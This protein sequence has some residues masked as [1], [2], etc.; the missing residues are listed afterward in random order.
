MISD[1]FCKIVQK[2]LPAEIV[3]EDEE[4]LV[5]KDIH[6][7]A[8][9]HLLVVPKKHFDQ[10]HAAS[11]E[12][13]DLLGKMVLVAG[14]AAKLAGTEEK[15]YRLIINQ[16]QDGGQLVPHLHLHLLGGKALGP[17]IIR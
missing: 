8:P 15:G 7:Q 17:K 2:E 1:I 9:V 14:K 16:G 4:F 12:D 5:I 3:Y 11:H 10:I 13:L 6:P